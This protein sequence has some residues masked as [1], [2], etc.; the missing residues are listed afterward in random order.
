MP[1]G[2]TGHNTTEPDICCRVAH[3]FPNAAFCGWQGL[4]CAW[5]GDSAGMRGFRMWA[6]LRAVC[7]GVRLNYR[8]K[9]SCMSEKNR[10]FAQ[11]YNTTVKTVKGTKK[12][13]GI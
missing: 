1:L 2:M 10:N 6:G 8:E 7:N 5:G 9:N 12:I 3:S 13:E 11:I 4:M